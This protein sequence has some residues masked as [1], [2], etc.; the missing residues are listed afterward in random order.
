IRTTELVQGR[1]INLAMSAR[2]RAALREVGL[3]DTML[4]HGIPMHARM[5]HGLD[6]SLHQIPYDA[7]GKQ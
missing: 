7:R 5:I 1:S 2:A 4:R 6:G 3:E